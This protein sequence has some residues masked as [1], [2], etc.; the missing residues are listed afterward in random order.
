MMNN[1]EVISQLKSLRQNSEC[2]AKGVY[3]DE[4]W[5]ADIEALDIAIKVVEKQRELNNLITDIKKDFNKDDTYSVSLVLEMLE[6]VRSVE[7]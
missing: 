2:H 6:S 4:I 7:E 1:Q 3:A 5:T